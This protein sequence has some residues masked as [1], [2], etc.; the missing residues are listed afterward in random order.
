MI[1]SLTDQTGTGTLR[2]FTKGARSVIFFM[3]PHTESLL[4]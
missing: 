3:K 1:I 2:D 4:F